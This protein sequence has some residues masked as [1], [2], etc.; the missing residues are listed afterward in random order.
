MYD[1]FIYGHAL[2]LYIII[3]IYNISACQEEMIDRE[4]TIKFFYHDNIYGLSIR[5]YFFSSFYCL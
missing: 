2:I 1:V 4:R 3:I 5:Y